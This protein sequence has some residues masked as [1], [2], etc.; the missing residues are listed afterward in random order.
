MRIDTSKTFFAFCFFVLC[1][2]SAIVLDSVVLDRGKASFSTIPGELER[3]L[4]AR[5][6]EIDVRFDYRYSQLPFVFGVLL[7]EGLLRESDLDGLAEDKMELIRRF[8]G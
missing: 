6:K 8:L 7:R 1:C 3:Y 5:R 4:S 2:R